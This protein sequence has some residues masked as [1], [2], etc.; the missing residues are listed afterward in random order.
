MR[1]NIHYCFFGFF[2]AVGS[3]V[4]AL[5]VTDINEHLQFK[6]RAAQTQGIVTNLI[7]MKSSKGSVS[8]LPVA[9]YKVNGAEFE[10]SDRI[11][12]PSW[13]IST[14][15]KVEVLYNPH[16]PSEAKIDSAF[17]AY[18]P[19]GM[20]SVVGCCFLAV[21]LYGTARHWKK[22]RLLRLLNS[23]GKTVV[24]TIMSVEPYRKEKKKGQHPYIATYQ[25]TNELDG[26]VYEGKSDPIYFESTSTG[27]F[28]VGG[29]IS[30]LFNPSNPRQNLAKIES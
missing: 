20:F 24:A 23:V 8:Y 19:G 10:V 27:R 7:R 2:V 1:L 28:Q 30:V 21:G 16:Q 22:E 26:K 18:F 9:T 6:K 5:G 14:G 3:I 17:W 12:H 13:S 11:T 15:D 4:L 29:N 25:F